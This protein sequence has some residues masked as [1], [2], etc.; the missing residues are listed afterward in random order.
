MVVDVDEVHG[1]VRRPADDEHDRHDEDHRR[2]AAQLRPRA[3]PAAAAATRRHRRRHQ[4][5]LSGARAGA[6]Q[7]GQRLTTVGRRRHLMLR[8]ILSLIHI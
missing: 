3:L 6:Y 4:P 5:R 7:A 8:H 2:H 1:V